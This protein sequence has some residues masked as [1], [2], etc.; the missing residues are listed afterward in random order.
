MS[1]T[2]IALAVAILNDSRYEMLA[3]TGLAILIAQVVGASYDL[4]DDFLNKF[5]R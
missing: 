1:T 2:Q 5:S 3:H 4:V